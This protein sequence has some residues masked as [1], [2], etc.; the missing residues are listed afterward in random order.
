[1]S[2]NSRSTSVFGRRTLPSAGHLPH[3]S[4]LLSHRKRQRPQQWLT[5]LPFARARTHTH[6]HTHMHARARAHARTHAHTHTHKV[7]QEKRLYNVY[8]IC[9]VLS[10]T[11]HRNYWS[12]KTCDQSGDRHED[13]T[14]SE[15]KF[16]WWVHLVC[17][18]RPP[19]C[20]CCFKMYQFIYLIIFSFIFL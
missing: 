10:E 1:M 20:S 8:N 19:P 3:D 12:S 4:L 5:T 15:L 13:S 11:I 18:A 7:K 16:E 14:G 9:L 6:T 2:P 17:M